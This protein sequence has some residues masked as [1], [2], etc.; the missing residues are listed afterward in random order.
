MSQQGGRKARA[1][2]LCNVT[3]MVPTSL[4]GR[5]WLAVEQAV[6]IGPHARFIDLAFLIPSGGGM[7]PYKNNGLGLS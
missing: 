4:Q 3:Q 2:T 7:I 5:I 1:L 6:Y